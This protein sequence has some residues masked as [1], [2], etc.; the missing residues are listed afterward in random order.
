MNEMEKEW[1]GKIKNLL[2]E[3]LE[4][5]DGQALARLERARNEALKGEPTK[6]RGLFIPLRWLMVGSF[7]T[8]SAAA[9]VFFI[10]LHSPSP[11]VLPAQNPEDFEIITASEKID[12][13]Q[14]LDFY[15]WLIT[16]ENG[17]RKGKST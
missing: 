2:D 5:I 1:I 7:A 17:E 9:L 6:D 11:G 12:F 13:Y 10:W 3:G 8:A 15:Q 4:R 16:H 14:N